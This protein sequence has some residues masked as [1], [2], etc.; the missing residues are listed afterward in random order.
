MATKLAE[1]T[2]YKARLSDKILA[3]A[4]LSAGRA[5]YARTCM[6]CHKL[7]G[8]GGDIGPD[9]TGSNRSNLDYLLTNII[10]PSGEVAREYMLTVVETKDGGMFSG[11]LV[12]ENKSTIRLRTATGAIE[13]IARA[14][15]AVSDS[16][17]V[18]ITRLATSMMP[19][20]QLLSL[21]PD[22]V[23][24]L[25]AYLR[26]PAQVPMRATS[27]S[28]SHFFN[29]RDLTGWDADPKVWSVES[30]EIV[31]RTTQGLKKNNFARSHL[32]FGDFRL[33][34]DVRL[35]GNQ[36]N[37][38]IQFRSSVLQDGAMKGYQADIGKSWWGKLYHEHGR[39]QLA[40]VARDQY[41]NLED[42]NSYE[43]LAVGH[44]IQ[45]ALNGQAC[46]DL[47]DPKGEL[48]GILGVQVH[49]GGPTEVRFRNFRFELDPKPELTTT[50]K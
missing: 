45:M 12:E 23:R 38:G 5:I 13:Q 30:G 44:R 25:I 37:S 46:V 33:I 50:R 43:I 42:W 22:E 48:R 47:V 19:E 4:D 39:G 10:D 34:V 14:D 18:S 7:F 16:D 49:S 27:E 9:I 21:S 2:K 17:G 15:I 35:L 20:G 26:N 28:L 32:D 8:S 11:L 3:A 31:G 1:I 29:G 41:V 24:D 40:S 36:G 6:V